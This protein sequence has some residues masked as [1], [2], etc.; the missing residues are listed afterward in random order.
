MGGQARSLGWTGK[1]TIAT[2]ILIPKGLL[3]MG[4]AVPGPRGM[5]VTVRY[6][7]LEKLVHGA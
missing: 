5:Q 6:F 4:I 1:L 7:D 2:S 3:V